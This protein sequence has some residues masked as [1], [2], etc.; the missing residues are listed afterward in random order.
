M[1]MVIEMGAEKGK[2]K[3]KKGFDDFEV[4][5]AFHTL[6]KAER[7]KQD[8][9]LMAAVQQFAKKESK[10]ISSIADL[11]SKAAEVA[12]DEDESSETLA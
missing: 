4:E 6:K 12:A 2:G 7:I 1:P 3:G 10:A 11:K 5:E 8:P 9:K